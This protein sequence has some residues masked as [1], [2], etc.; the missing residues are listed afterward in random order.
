M[1]QHDAAYRMKRDYDELIARPWEGRAICHIDLD[2]FFAAVLELDHPKL[3][4]KPVIVGRN[5]ERGVVATANYEARKFGVHSAMSAV[6]AA[7]LCPDAIWMQG[8]FDR[9]H[10]VAAQVLAILESYT[11]L[12]Q[13][14]SI[15]EA[16][17]DISPGRSKTAHPLAISAEILER[18]S[19]LGISGSIG[20]STSKTVSKI[21]SDILKPRGLTVVFPGE[22]AAFLAPLSIHKLGGIGP[23]AAEKLKALGVNTL[24]QLAQFTELDLHHIFG[25]N[26][27]NFI[28][29][30]AGR[31]LSPVVIDEETK[32]ISNETTLLSD[33]S[34]LDEITKE[35]YPLAE[36]VGW[37][38]RKAG[39]KGRT[40]SVKIRFS[41][42]QIKTIS[43]TFDQAT[44][45]E[46]MFYPLAKELVANAGVAG[47]RIRLVGIGISNFSSE[48]LE[49][50][51]LF[52]L[53][54]LH[55]ERPA[56]L[57]VEKSARLNE[58]IDAIREKF[59]YDAIGGLSSHREN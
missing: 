41:D 7:E 50:M 32:S 26:T 20:L 57:A 58:Q 49:Q 53:E 19:L 59:G 29:R 55:D 27:Q 40:L 39:L 6:R 54:G 16:Y 30:A 4:G 18:V 52:D 33:I 56:G 17:F 25:S 48:G 14:T 46:R 36:K 12:I 10:E 35:L 22:E 42:F 24:G 34:S 47:K 43:K 51:S 37:R 44:D 5:H 21:A 9:Y 8:S 38:L 31:D 28:D 3:K 15:D 13:R 23:V 2:A 1:S 45:D 11:P